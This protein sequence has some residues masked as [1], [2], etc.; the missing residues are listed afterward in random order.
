[1]S[2]LGIALRY[3]KYRKKAKN[4]FKIHSPFVYGFLEN[5]FR[6]EK[7]HD[8]FKKL[9]AFYNELKDSERVIETVDF[10]AK[11]TEKDYS[12]YFIKLGKL[13]RQR[14]HPLKHLHIFYNLSKYIKPSTMLEFGTAAGVSTIYLKKPLPE[15]KMVTIEGC[16]TLSSIAEENIE[17][18]G[19]KNVEVVQGNFE[20]VL[21]EVL[22]KF[23]KLDFVFFDGNHRKQPTL[24]Y[25][26]KCMDRVHP[27][28]VFLF[29]DI[30]W[31]KGM[32]EAWEEI[33]ADPRVSVTMDI[34]WFG[35]V[36]FRKG[37]AKQDFVVKF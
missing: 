17:K 12:E 14:S 16:A 9:D 35:L 27:G 21:D 29:D 22:N 15:S 19:V 33:K 31:S 7:Y 28:T 8:D 18:A 24:D 2:A 37:I 23:E 3:L 4:R 34:F 1:M 32:E 10:G 25:F 6:E 5:V 13:V 30:H 20:Q 36:F 26:E 11:A